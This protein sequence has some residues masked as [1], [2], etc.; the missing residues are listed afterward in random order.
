VQFYIGQLVWIVSSSKDVL[1]E[2]P[3][4]VVSAYQDIP[5][6]FLY[7]DEA[8]REWLE[9][10]DLGEGWVYDIMYKGNIEVAVSSEWLRPWDPHEQ[11]YTGSHG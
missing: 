2:P 1:Y 3:A 5:R 6:V 11:P 8:N 10:E 9:P 4:L 7:N